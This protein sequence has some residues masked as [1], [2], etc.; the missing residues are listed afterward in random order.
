LRAVRDAGRELRGY[1]DTLSRVPSQPSLAHLFPFY[2]KFDSKGREIE[3]NYTYH[4]NRSRSS[5]RAK[6]LDERDIVIKF[7]HKYNESTHRLCAH[8]GYAPELL[9]VERNI[10][11]TWIVVI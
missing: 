2:R 1:F 3:F 10:I 8:S 7:T 9:H 11:P 5:F 4:L 6:T